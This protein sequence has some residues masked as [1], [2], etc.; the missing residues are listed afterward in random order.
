M[1]F[2][3]AYNQL[4]PSERDFVDGFIT[5]LEREAEKRFERLTVTLA[6]A[7]T[8]IRTDELDDRTRF[9]FAKPLVAAAIRERV[10]LLA[11]ER[12][13]TAERII[14]EHAAL[15]LSNMDDFVERYQDG[16]A[17]I[18]LNNVSRAQMAAVQQIETEEIYGPSGT[19]RKIKLKLYNKQV[20]LDALAKFNGLDKGDSPEAI[21]YRALPAN[22]VEMP[23]NMTTEQAAEE[24]AKL[25]A[26]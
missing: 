14:K 24:Y 1:M 15:G 8:N 5:Y 7:A 17:S 19:K 11:S 22:S 10:E 2:V 21:A 3:S 25:I 6:R 18:N 12:D 20:S 26:D 13:L 23:A 4:E 9:L 16:S